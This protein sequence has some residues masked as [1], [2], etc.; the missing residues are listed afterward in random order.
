MSIDTIARGL[1]NEALILIQQLSGQG[2]VGN[3]TTSQI[4]DFTSAVN[5][6]LVWSSIT[7]KPTTF[8]PSAH[9]HSV[10]DIINLTEYIQD[11]MSTTLVA[12]SNVTLN[13]NDTLNTLTISATGGGGGGGDM[14]KADNLSGLTDYATAR[15]NL[16][17]G[18]LATLSSIPS[19]SI[20]DSTSTGRSVLTG[21]NAGAIRTTLGLGSL[22]TQSTITA[23]QISDPT[24]V[25][26]TESIMVAASDETTT[27]T[28]GTA[29]VTFFVPYNFTLTE[30]FIGNTTASSSGIVTV[31]VKK[32]GT[33]IFTTKPS[34]GASQ[35]TSLTGTGSV[36]AVLSTTSLTKADKITIDFDAAGTGAKGLKV[37]FIG[38]RT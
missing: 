12:G 14:F 5:N 27:I 2:G 7:G 13:Y 25:K 37:Y 20:S 1:A 24:N 6:L 11:T 38:Q 36:N 4:T 21:A 31:N 22:A 28:V 30:V 29:K 15:T 33:T 10:S 18:S 32:N 19:T 8:T 17:L 23:S 34:I 3:I 35:D 9:T 26:T 16:G